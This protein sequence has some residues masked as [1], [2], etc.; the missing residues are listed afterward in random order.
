M[1]GSACWEVLVVDNNSKD[2]TRE[3]VEQFIRTYPG[4]F[5][6]FFEARQGKSAALNSGV[7]EAHGEILAFVDD[8]VTV[9]PDWLYELVGPLSDSQWAGTG[10]RVYLPID[11]TP[12]SW[13]AIEGNHSLVSILALFDLGSEPV[14]ITTP[15]I[16]NNMA[17]RK[18]IFT[19]YGGFRTD[20]GPSPGS[21][22]RHEDTEFGLRV[23]GGGEKILYVPSAIVR[24]AVAERRLKKE[25]FLAYHYDYGRALIRVKGSRPSV[26]IIPRPLISFSNRLLNILPRKV[27]WWLRESE[28]KKR[29]FNKCHV[30][31]IAGELAEILHGSSGASMEENKVDLK[32]GPAVEATTS[33]R[34]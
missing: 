9:E 1:P 3:V 16:G 29:F 33:N 15:P 5:R 28:P 17:F 26:G 19:K 18:A 21:E 30:W 34:P 14:S 2:Q 11:F 23:L 31:A 24:H 25:Y 6:Y 32:P 22:I 10:G 12:P 8:D 4:R 27:Y 13:M 20:L 7:R